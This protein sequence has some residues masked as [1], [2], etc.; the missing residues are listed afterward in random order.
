MFVWKDKEERKRGWGW[1]IFKVRPFV[2]IVWKN[3]NQ[4]CLKSIPVYLSQ[5]KLVC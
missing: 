5:M 1:P 4:I 2:R 3:K